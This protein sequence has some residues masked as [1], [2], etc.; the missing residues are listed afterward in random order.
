MNFF[1]YYCRQS[2]RLSIYK[3]MEKRI[4]EIEKKI[5]QLD[6]KLSELLAMKKSDEKEKQE[7]IKLQIQLEQMR[8]DHESRIATEKWKFEKDARV[9][10]KKD[11]LEIWLRN[12]EWIVKDEKLQ[13]LK[14]AQESI[15]KFVS[16]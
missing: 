12:D 10:A 8:I 14:H 13:K 6:A 16:F 2:D 11:E 3:E 9:Q 1:K 5:D 15:Q 7:T 4:D